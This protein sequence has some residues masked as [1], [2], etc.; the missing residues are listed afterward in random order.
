MELVS[1]LSAQGRTFPADLTAGES[2]PMASVRL[3][4]IETHIERPGTPGPA[5]LLCPH[6]LPSRCPRVLHLAPKTPASGILSYRS[7]PVTPH[8]AV[9][10]SKTHRW[11]CAPPCRAPRASSASGRII[12]TT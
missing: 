1:V 4:R 12:S 3:R 6:T 2:V 9:S 8:S 10:P 7:R 11:H 5:S